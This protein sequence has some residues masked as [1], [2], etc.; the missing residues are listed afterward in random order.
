MALSQEMKRCINV[1]PDCYRSRYSQEP[2]SGDGWGARRRRAS[3]HPP[4]TNT[5]CVSLSG[6]HISNV[7]N[8]AVLF[9]SQLLFSNNQ[10]D[11]LAMTE[12]ISRGA[13]SPSPRITSM[14]T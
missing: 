14:I 12:L 11:H 5:K 10:I 4:G 6:S 1:C 2:L 8:G 9:A 7:R 13:I 3:A